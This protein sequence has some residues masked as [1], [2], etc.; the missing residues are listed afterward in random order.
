M[1]RAAASRRRQLFTAALVVLAAAACVL[2][3][4]GRTKVDAL[5]L[6][7]GGDGRAQVLASSE[8]RVC[9]A[10]TN[11]GFGR[12]RAW[13]AMCGIRLSSHCGSHQLR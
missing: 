7:V 2:W 11:I 3:W 12:D 8:G 4:H 1:R 9:V 5:I 13:T 6:F 10:L